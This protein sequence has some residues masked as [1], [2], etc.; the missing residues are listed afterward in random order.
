MI[1]ADE[2]TDK[3]GVK[4]EFGDEVLFNGFRCTV[5]SIDLLDK[6]LGIHQVDNRRTCIRVGKDEVEV[7]PKP[8]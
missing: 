5:Y 1:S 7:I 3:N 8:F 4:I 6:S 2:F